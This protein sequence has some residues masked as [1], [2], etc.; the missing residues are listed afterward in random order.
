MYKKEMRC[1]SG[2]L[3][4][5]SIFRAKIAVDPGLLGDK[6]AERYRGMESAPEG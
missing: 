4:H 1:F 2:F 5:N 3:H 6:I